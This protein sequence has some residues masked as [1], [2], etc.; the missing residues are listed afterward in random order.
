MHWRQFVK[1]KEMVLLLNSQRLVHLSK[2]VVLNKNF[3]TLFGCVR[4]MLDEGNS[5][6]SW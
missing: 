2:I 1:K 3:V 6:D 5:I 4:L